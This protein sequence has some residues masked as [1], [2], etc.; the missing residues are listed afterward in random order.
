MVPLAR[1]LATRL[2]LTRQALAAGVIGDY[3]AQLI[4]GATRVLGDPVLRDA[5]N[6]DESGVR[7]A[8]EKS[9]DSGAVVGEVSATLARC[10]AG[11]RRGAG[12][13]GPDCG[14]GR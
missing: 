11:R 13:G 6:A 14:G 7:D 2:P 10:R 9:D 3:K 8:D 1:D 4:A 12:N 5:E